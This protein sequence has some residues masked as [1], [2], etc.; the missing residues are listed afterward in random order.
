MILLFF[1]VII[2][3][4]NDIKLYFNKGWVKLQRYMNPDEE[5][6]MPDHEGVEPAVR[7]KQR[8]QRT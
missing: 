8:L 2:L 6:L 4:F 3:T 7:E 5:R 1:P